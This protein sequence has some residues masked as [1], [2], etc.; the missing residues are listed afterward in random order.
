MPRVPYVGYG[1][2]VPCQEPFKLNLCF[3]HF[4]YPVELVK[5]LQYADDVTC[6]VSDLASF[7]ALTGTLSTFQRATGARL[8]PTKTKGLRLGKWQSKQLPFVAS[9]VDDAMKI[10]GIWFGYGSPES[11]LT[12]NEKVDLVEA[13]LKDFGD[14]YI[15]LLGTV[16]VVNRFVY[17][18][19]SSG[20]RR[21][22]TCFRFALVFLPCSTCITV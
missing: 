19:F 11:P 2:G 5:C 4:T 22:Q 7:R 3:D 1:R 17:P 9:W 10:N 13:R 8:N 18:L 21:E 6:V 14:R 20:L 16:T 12:W 15:S